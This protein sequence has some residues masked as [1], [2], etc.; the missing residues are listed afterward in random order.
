MCTRKMNQK[1][2]PQREMMGFVLACMPKISSN[3]IKSKFDQIQVWSN[4]NLIKSEFDQIRGTGA[5]A[6]EIVEEGQEASVIIL[7]KGRACGCG[8]HRP[9]RYDLMFEG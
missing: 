1:R 2:Q 9:G 4:P 6:S 3:L 7:Q 8:P 5:A